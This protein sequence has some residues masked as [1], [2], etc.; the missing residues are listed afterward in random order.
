[1]DLLKNKYGWIKYDH[2][3]YESRFAKFYEGYWLLKNLDMI[4]VKHIS[5]A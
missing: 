1:M 3:H 4:N 5:R 2:K